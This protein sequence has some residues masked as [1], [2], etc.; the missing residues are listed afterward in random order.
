MKAQTGS[1]AQKRLKILGDDEIAALYS[2]PHFTPEERIEY[3]SLSPTEKAAMIQLHSIKSRFYY[4][5]QLGYFKARQLFFVFSLHEVAE[6]AS[7][8]QAHYFPDFRRTD[9]A[10]TKVPRLKQQQLILALCDYRFYGRNAK[11]LR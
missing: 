6:D 5:L 3:F 7:Y 2:R 8:I 9:L 11:P 4:I 10:I 1:N